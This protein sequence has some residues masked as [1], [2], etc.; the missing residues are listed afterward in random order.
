MGNKKQLLNVTFDLYL[1]VYACVCVFWLDFY[2]ISIFIG[3]LIANPVFI[4]DLRVNRA[5]KTF[6]RIV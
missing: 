6:K 5:Q 1:C 3:N 2:G 4:Y